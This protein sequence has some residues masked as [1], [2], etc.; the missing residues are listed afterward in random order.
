MNSY[1]VTIQMK[2]LW[3]DFCMVPFI[4]NMLENE[5]WNSYR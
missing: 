4:F 2:P 1:G 3:Q 5:I